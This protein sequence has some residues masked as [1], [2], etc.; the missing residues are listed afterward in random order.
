MKSIFFTQQGFYC[1]TPSIFSESCNCRHHKS[2]ESLQ[3][4]TSG[5]KTLE[6]YLPRRRFSQGVIDPLKKEKFIIDVN[7]EGEGGRVS[8]TGNAS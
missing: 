3:R 2:H 4:K 6:S 5:Q 7:S 1:F 8:K